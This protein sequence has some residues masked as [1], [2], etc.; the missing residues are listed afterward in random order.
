[1]RWNSPTTS[2]MLTSSAPVAVSQ[3]ETE[4]SVGKA[5]SRTPSWSGMAKFISPMR[6]GMA[7]KKII[8]VPCAEKIWL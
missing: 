1:M 7:T 2:E 4:L 6:K 5:T 3:N 8:S